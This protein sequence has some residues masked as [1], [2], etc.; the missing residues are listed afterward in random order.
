MR[1]A[2]FILLAACGGETRAQTI[3]RYSLSIL[4]NLTS[5]N[6]I[7]TNA[8]SGDHSTSHLSRA[9]WN[10]MLK[11]TVCPYVAGTRPRTRYMSAIRVHEHRRC[12]PPARS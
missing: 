9:E 5:L 6:G 11:S 3:E 1:L 10:S 4:P 7:L 8:L 12:R 2:E